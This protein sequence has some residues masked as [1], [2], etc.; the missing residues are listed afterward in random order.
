MKAKIMLGLALLC[1]TASLSACDSEKLPEETVVWTPPATMA[2]E[3]APTEPATEPATELET[4]SA[5]TAALFEENLPEDSYTYFADSEGEYATAVI[6]RAQGEVKNLTYWAVEADYTEE[7]K[8]TCTSKTELFHLDTL[9]EDHPLVIRMEFP[10]IMPLRAISFTDSTGAEQSF[11]LTQ[12]GED[13]QPVL[14]Q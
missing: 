3:P 9:P 5:L 4:A 2:T 8:L 14:M 13:G 12:S 7:G 11:Y 6:F 1:L 10:E